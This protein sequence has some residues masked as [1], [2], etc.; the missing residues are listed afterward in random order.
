VTRVSNLIN[1][2]AWAALV[3]AAVAAVIAVALV[4]GTKPA[5]AAFPRK[6]GAIAFVS[7]RDGGDYHI[8]RMKADGSGET[9][10]SD[11][12]GW[13]TGPN[14]SANGKKIV[15][16]HCDPVPRAC[17]A[18]IYMMNADG[19]RERQLTDAVN[20]DA[21]WFPTHNKIAFTSYRDSSANLYAMTFDASG[22]ATELTRLTHAE[23]TEMCPAVAPDGERIAFLSYRD[24]DQGLYVMKAAPES[25][26]N[27][28][29][30]LAGSMP[31]GCYYDWSPDGTKIAFAR[32]LRLP[33]GTYSPDI[34][35]MNADGTGKTNLTKTPNIF[36]NDPAFS[37]SGKEIAFTSDRDGNDD[38]WR[39]RADGSNQTQLTDDPARDS[40]PDWQ[41]LPQRNTSAC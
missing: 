35:S 12:A 21:S 4:I 34:F 16:E 29:V 38:I 26:T 14:W 2:K 8:W 15:F 30:K 11:M 9:Y 1:D 5:K 22:S 33:D 20:V 27:R 13:N 31:F 39:M 19:S 10:I 7:N 3:L 28:P 23:T 25:A 40:G 6:D 24:D 37:P 32:Y 17:P 36:E 41:P 18:M